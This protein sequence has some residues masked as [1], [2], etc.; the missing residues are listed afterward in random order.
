MDYSKLG[1]YLDWNSSGLLHPSVF[2]V[3]RS[4]WQLY[5]NPDS[6]HFIGQQS[7]SYLKKLEN[8]LLDKLGAG[9][10]KASPCSSCEVNGYR[11]IFT[12]GAS[13]ANISLLKS[14]DSIIVSD[15]DHP[16]VRDCPSATVIPVNENGMINLDL[17]KQKLEI[18]KSKT[19]VSAILAN[20]ETGVINDIRQVSDLVHSYGGHVHT[21]AVQAFGRIDIDL[22]K[23]DV[24][25]MTISALKCGGPAG[26]GAL[27]HREYLP[28]FAWGNKARLGTIPIPLVAGLVEA[29]EVQRSSNQYLENLLPNE[30]IV[31]NS[32]NRLANTT[33]IL[34]P[35]KTEV[36]MALDLA[37]IC[38]SSGA[39]CTSGTADKAHS[40]IAMGINEDTIRISSGWY[41]KNDD[42]DKCYQILKLLL[43]L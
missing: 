34:C 16:S 1:I 30:L 12:S 23:L 18:A 21:D 5:T 41:N 15:V 14:Y 3:M 28:P 40:A 13:E 24:D 42:F 33:C 7:K 17:L 38:V 27:I 35:N 2:E 4:C 11:V 8:K 39:A 22:Q 10:I 31:G 37:G 43:N 6:K 26:V 9:I 32:L 29:L 20:H 19:L 36:M 25:Y